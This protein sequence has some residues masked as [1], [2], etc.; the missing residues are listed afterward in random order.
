MVCMQ[1]EELASR[2]R[3]TAD[4]RDA[5][6]KTVLVAAI[7]VAHQLALPV[8]QEGARMLASAAVGEVIHDRLERHVLRRGIRPQIRTMCLAFAWTEH[9]HRRFIRMQHTLSQDL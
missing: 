4:L 1:L 7:V 6:G 8:A 9:L 3:G 2:M 5:P